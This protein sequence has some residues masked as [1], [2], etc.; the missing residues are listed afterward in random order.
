MSSDSILIREATATDEAGWRR[1]WDAYL[2]YYEESLQDEITAR[3]WQCILEPAST[4][5]ALVGTQRGVVIGFAVTVMHART[6]SLF[7]TCYVEDLFVTP[8]RRGSGVGHSLLRN[9]MASAVRAGATSVYWHTRANNA[10]ARRLYD[11]FALADDVVRYR[12]EL[13]P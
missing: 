10:P 1:L 9:V 8:E 3:T 11:R 4:M 13:R 2:N 12:A 7:P 6:W 5:Q